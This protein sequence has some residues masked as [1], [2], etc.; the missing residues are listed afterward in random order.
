MRRHQ[1]KNEETQSTKRRRL[2]C[3]SGTL[4]T[5]STKGERKAETQL[6]HRKGLSPVL[7]PTSITESGLEQLGGDKLQLSKAGT[8]RGPAHSPSL[9]RRAGPCLPQ[10]LRG[11]PRRSHRLFCPKRSGKSS[12]SSCSCYSAVAWR[13]QGCAL[14]PGSTSYLCSVLGRIGC[15]RKLSVWCSRSFQMKPSPGSSHTKIFRRQRQEAAEMEHR[16]EQPLSSRNLGEPGG[17]AAF[18]H[19]ILTEPVDFQNSSNVN[20][21]WKQRSKQHLK[22]IPQPENERYLKNI[23]NNWE[24]AQNWSFLLLQCPFLL[25]LQLKV[26]FK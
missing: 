15:L 13:K 3:Y 23:P 20:C 21:C 5:T 25:S 8:V 4:T 7:S 1:L 16:G 9:L 22:E 19:V 6:S 26:N 10:W 11:D 2:T 18:L 24:E 12:S 17:R 14:A